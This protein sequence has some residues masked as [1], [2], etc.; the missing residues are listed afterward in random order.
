MIENTKIECQICDAIIEDVYLFPELIARFYNWKNAGR[1]DIWYCP[2][3][4]IEEIRH[5]EGLNV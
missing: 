4:S 2:K 5:F 3:H 1:N